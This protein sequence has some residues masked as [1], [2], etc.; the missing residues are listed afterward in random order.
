MQIQS[1]LSDTHI[2]EL[3]AKKNTFDADAFLRLLVVQ[4]STQ[5]PLEPMND[6]DFF[7][8]MAQLGMVDGIGRMRKGMELSQG[9]SF[10]GK[11]VEV[12]PNESGGEMV[13]GVVEAV[14]VRNGNVYVLVGGMPYGLEQVVRIMM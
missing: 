9:A 12:F 2:P 10:I 5:N 13:R 1:V 11:V 6:R 14:E 7:A 3:P 4:L 8:Q